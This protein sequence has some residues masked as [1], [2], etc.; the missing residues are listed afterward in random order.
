MA[1]TQIQHI[2]IVDD[3]KFVRTTLQITIEQLGDY[4]CYQAQN[5]DDAI[6]TLNHNPQI[7]LIFC[8]LNMPDEDGITLLT[9]LA[10]LRSEVRIVLISGED[11]EVLQS[12]QTLGSKFGLNIIGIA[13]KPLT[14]QRVQ[15]LI[16]LAETSRAAKPTVPGQRFTEADLRDALSNKNVICFFQPQV[17]LSNR[18]VIGFEAL[19][20]IRHPQRGLITPNLFIDLAEELDLIDQ[21]TEQVVQDA[22]SHFSTW[23]AEQDLT[24]SLNF[25]ASTMASDDFPDWLSRMAKT[26]HLEPERI[27]CELTETVLSNNP[28]EL[29]RNLLRLR[30]MKFKLSIDDFGT[31]YASLEQ[32]HEIPF[33]EVKIDMCFVRDFLNNKRSRTV[34]TNCLQLCSEMD[35]KTVSEGIEDQATFT[36]LAKLG[37]DYGQGYYIS[38]PLDA[39][40]VET[41]LNEYAAVSEIN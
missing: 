13:E 32:L 3:H 7:Q 2:L 8:D 30:L 1:Q 14:S 38:K 36:A 33:N 12:A 6:A 26:Y 17:Q 31:G 41:F 4:S 15:H 22:L 23:D 24:L 18:R 25:S 34:V 11:I 9:R 28:H 37:C 35:I 16:Q 5:G 39:S 29:I 19:A 21:V 27:I 20:R 40:D 10:K